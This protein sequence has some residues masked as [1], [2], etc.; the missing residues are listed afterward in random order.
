MAIKRE[1]K[2]LI[3]EVLNQTDFKRIHEYMVRTKWVWMN[4]DDPQTPTM[5]ELII[6]AKRQLKE[7]Y[8]EAKKT[9]SDYMTVSSGGFYAF[10]NYGSFMLLFSIS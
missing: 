10:Y 6:E 4:R 1:I 3:E 2:E 8:K 7:A 5:N 9:N